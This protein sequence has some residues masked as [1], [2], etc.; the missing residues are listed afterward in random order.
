MVYHRILSIVLYM[1]ANAGDIRIVGLIP[2]LGR[3]PGG[4]HGK[5][6]Q[7]S[8]LENLIDRGAWQATV[9]RFTKN[10]TRLKRPS[11]NNR[12]NTGKQK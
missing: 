2:E 9:H 12:N 11:M 3:S 6:L 1:P 7:D 10:L 4:G 5:P 8:C